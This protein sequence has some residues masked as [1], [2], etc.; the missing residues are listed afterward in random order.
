MEDYQDISAD[1]KG[2]GTNKTVSLN[3]GGSV[4]ISASEGRYYSGGSIDF[5][6]ASA[7]SF[8]YSKLCRFFSLARET[9]MLSFG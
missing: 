3:S 8:D 7:D 6:G 5:D 2:S 4:T 9:L 1:I